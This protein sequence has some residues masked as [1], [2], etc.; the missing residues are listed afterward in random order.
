MKRTAG[1][2]LLLAA[3]CAGFDPPTPQR[4]SSLHVSPVRTNW[5]PRTGALILRSRFQASVDSAWLAG[6]FDGVVVADPRPGAP[7]LRAQLFG[8]LG[9][10]AADLL[11]RPDRIVGW[12]PQ[13]H[14]GVDCAIPDEA[15]RH[16]LLFMGA[17]LAEELLGQDTG[18]R[19][20]GIRE[21]DGG[22]WLRLQPVLPGVEVHR[23]VSASDPAVKR[24]RFSWMLGIH[25]EEDWRSAEECL[26]TAPGLRLRIRLLER[27]ATPAAEAPAIE[28]TLP[29]DVRLVA[30]SRK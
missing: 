30:G 7:R 15:A 14:E 19:V 12:F 21:E 5:Y 24:R 10:K 27:S 28:L 26:I 2:L 4:L 23:F 25:W 11:V 1:L 18:D 6:E 20:T 9:P 22:A 13:T 3:G 17:S 29:Q 16:P 8:D